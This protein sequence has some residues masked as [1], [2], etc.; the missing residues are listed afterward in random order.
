MCISL[1]VPEDII[2][3]W[4]NIVDLISELIEVP[5]AFINQAILPSLKILNTNSSSSLNPFQ[6]GQ[7]VSAKG[8]YCEH[9]IKKKE[10]LTVQNALTDEKWLN[11]PEIELNFI[12]YLGFP[13]F[14]LTGTSLALSVSLIPR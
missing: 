10:K 13:I 8:L 1:K 7:T 12:S 4:Q 5:A 6:T 11:S 2:D 14:Y 3:R 9:V